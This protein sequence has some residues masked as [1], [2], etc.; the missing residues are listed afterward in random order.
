MPEDILS[1]IRMVALGRSPE[2]ESE[3]LVFLL[4]CEVGTLCLEAVK[5]L[6]ALV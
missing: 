3:G 4:F 6:V 2:Y 5:M 1:M